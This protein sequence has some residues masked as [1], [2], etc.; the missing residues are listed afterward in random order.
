MTIITYTVL[1]SEY[2]YVEKTWLGKGNL[3]FQA[4]TIIYAVEN[5]I[6]CKVFP[7]TFL[8]LGNT[9]SALFDN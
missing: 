9:R 6:I 8:A 3:N 4:I 7:Q 1:D 2:V 5:N